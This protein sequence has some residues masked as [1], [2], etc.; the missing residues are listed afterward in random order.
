MTEQGYAPLQNF[1]EQDNESAIKL[2]TNGRAS[3]GAKSR[4]LDFHYFWIKDSTKEMGIHIRHCHTLK[5]LAN[6]FTKSLHGAL[7]FRKF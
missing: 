3:A 7:L 2:E 1:L 4:Y 6:F 5:M